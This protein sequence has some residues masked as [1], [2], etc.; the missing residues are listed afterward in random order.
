MT[1]SIT[2]ALFFAMLVLA[3]L[4]GPGVMLVMLRTLSHGFAAG[5]AA[6]VGIVAGDFVFIALAI[7]G[8]STL[9]QLLGSFFLVVKYA[10][11]AY[12][13]YLGVKMLLTKPS[14]NK[15]T[16]NPTVRHATH[17]FAGLL[18]TLS[19]P[20]AILFYISFFPAFIDLANVNALDIIII[21]FVA[22]VA[23]GGVML[24]Y[25][26]ATLKSGKIFKGTLGARYLRYGSGSLLIGSG[27]YI[28]IRS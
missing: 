20:K 25:A 12:L 26:Y 5:A 14:E 15:T 19:N 28:A 10:G 11:A 4:P 18:T 27:S 9:S 8:L 16:L 1:L 3:V 13:I 6:A 2:L 23:I 21:L 22:T 17:F 7:Y 24:L